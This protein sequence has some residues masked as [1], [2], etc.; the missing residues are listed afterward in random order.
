MTVIVHFVEMRTVIVMRA[1]SHVQRIVP[2]HVPRVKFRI[3]MEC[4]PQIRWVMGPVI[5][6]FSALSM[7][8]TRMIVVSQV[9]VRMMRVYVSH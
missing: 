7:K 2:I 1:S 6:Y 4:V 5:R 3:V 9:T 8:M